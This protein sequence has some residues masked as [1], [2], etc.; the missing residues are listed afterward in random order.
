MVAKR[1]IKILLPAAVFVIAAGLTYLGV[2]QWTTQQ[3]EKKTKDTLD[4]V[5]GLVEGEVITLPELKTLSGETV[6]LH[7]LPADKLLLVFFTP[8]CP[9][10][11]LDAGLWRDLHAESAKRGKAFYL[12]DVGNDRDALEK[13]TT[14]HN[15]ANVPVLFDDNRQVGRALKVNIVPQYL[16]VARDGKVLRRRDGV[17]RYGQPPGPEEL[18]KF[19]QSAGD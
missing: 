13:F 17:R 14:A 19:F 3:S 8:A 12:I 7:Q 18:A 2:T 4:G 15:L 1:P 9:G 11:A 16:L 5:Q 10:C 6:A